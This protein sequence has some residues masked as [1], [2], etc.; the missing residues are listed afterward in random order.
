M[1]TTKRKKKEKKNEETHHKETQRHQNWVTKT[2]IEETS[3]N[4]TIE[5]RRTPKLPTPH[6]DSRKPLQTH[7]RGNHFKPTTLTR[8]SPH[9][10]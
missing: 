1:K 8:R 2:T 3:S 6:A 10:D 5:L 7:D 4:Q 9:A